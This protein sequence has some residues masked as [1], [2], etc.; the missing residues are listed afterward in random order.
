M[1]SVRLRVVETGC[2]KSPISETSAISA[3]K[4]ESSP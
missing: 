1:I 4:S 2:P 3:G